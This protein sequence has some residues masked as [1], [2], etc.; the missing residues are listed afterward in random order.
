VNTL[1]PAWAHAFHRR[2]TVG[3]FVIGAFGAGAV[4]AAFVVAGRVTGSQRRIVATLLL[5]GGGMIAVA[6]TAWLPLAFVFLFVAGFGYLASH[7]HAISRLQLAV[8]ERERGGSWR[9][10]RSRPR[11]ASVRKPRGRSDCRR[12][13]RAGRRWRAR[14]PGAGGGGSPVAARAPL[15]VNG[16]D[17]HKCR[18]DAGCTDEEAHTP[19]VA[20]GRSAAVTRA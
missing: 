4:A 14:T 20:P 18:E 1:A 5:L 6:V 16:Q 3:G 11:A 13:G 12:R 8:E 2:D 9:S 17:E 7:T 15:R 10:G 19:T